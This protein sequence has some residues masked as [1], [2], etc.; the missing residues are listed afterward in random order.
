MW[1]SNFLE[2]KKAVATMCK[3]DVMPFIILSLISISCVFFIYLTWESV[4]ITDN[5]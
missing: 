1:M 2:L 4:K 3:A 5:Q